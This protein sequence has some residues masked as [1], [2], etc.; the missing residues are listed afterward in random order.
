MFQQPDSINK[1]QPIATESQSLTEQVEQNVLQATEDSAAHSTFTTKSHWPVKIDSVLM[2]EQGKPITAKAAPLPKYY[3]DSFFAK[4][5]LL[6]SELQGGR[7][8]IAGDPVPYSLRTDNLVTPVLLLGILLLAFCVRR[9]SKFFVFQIRNF[10]HVVRTDS[11]IERESASEKRYLY[12][13][14]IY[15]G[16]VLALVFFFYTKAYISDTYVTYSEYTLMGIYLGGILAMFL[17]EHL[18]QSAVNNVLFSPRECSLWTATQLMTTAWAGILLTPMILLMAYF[19]WNIQNV[20]IYTLVVI[21]FVKIL[22]FYKC[23]QI[24]FRKKG[25]FLQI[26]LYFC[27]LEIIPPVL[28]WG[29]L[30]LVANYLKVNF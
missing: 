12:F 29:I 17:F 16:I 8:G 25:V 24:F 6:H 30:V 2:P 14:E 7:Y 26:F 9:S 23:Y 20:L 27:T 5:S 3:K 13:A 19:G 4:D 22:L 11:I 18:V 28:T 10:F 15:T 21:I 1:V